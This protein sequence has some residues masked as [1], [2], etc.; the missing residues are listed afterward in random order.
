MN[1]EIPIAVVKCKV[2]PLTARY[3]NGEYQSVEREKDGV[4]RVAVLGL[5]NSHSKDYK[6]AYASD[7]LLVVHAEGQGY[8]HDQLREKLQEKGL[9]LESF[10]PIEVPHG[11]GWY[12][13]FKST[14]R[15][16]SRLGLFKSQLEKEKIDDAPMI[17]GENHANAWV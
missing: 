4:K 7:P 16:K 13:G 9:W 8:S 2:G 14:P 15:A 10:H 6:V 1:E 11:D 3:Q 5:D 12:A 17:D